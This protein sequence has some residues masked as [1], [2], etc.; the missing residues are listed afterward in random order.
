MT[1]EMQIRMLLPVSDCEYILECVART[2]RE[3][4]VPKAKALK[5]LV[6][7]A[8][9]LLSVSLADRN[10]KVPT[11]LVKAEARRVAARLL[12]A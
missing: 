6:N 5:P 4:S 11:L 12:A 1:R 8:S 2:L 3:N 9:R 10:L 7:A